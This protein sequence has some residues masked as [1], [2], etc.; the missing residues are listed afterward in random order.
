MTLS[1]TE[2][3][4]HQNG[5]MRISLLVVVTL[6]IAIITVISYGVLEYQKIS[7]TIAKAEQLTEEKNYDKA[8]EELELVQERWIIKKLG[9]KRQEIAEKLEENKQLLKEQINYKNGVEKIREKDWE[10]AKELFLSVSEKSLFYPD[11][12]NK[13]EVLDEILGCEYRKGEYKMRIF[14]SQGRVTGIVDGELKEEIPGSMLMYNE[15]DK[16]YTAVIFDPRDT[17]TYEFYAVKAG[18]YQFTLVSVV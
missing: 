7:G 13:I 15:E 3:V 11:A 10:G 1:S 16:T 14:D 18:N 5:F 6:V 17:Y 9:I 4:N 2:K 8:I 12:I